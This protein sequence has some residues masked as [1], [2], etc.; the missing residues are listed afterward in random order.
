MAHTSGFS[1]MADLDELVETDH[2]VDVRCLHLAQELMLNV[3]VLQS[4]KR[5]VYQRAPPRFS[6]RP[7]EPT[8][9]GQ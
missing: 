5:A 1:V 7:L 6:Y 4:Y 3:N 8:K 2:F 9:F